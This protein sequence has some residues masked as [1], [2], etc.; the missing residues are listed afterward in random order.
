MTAAAMILN[1]REAQDGYICI[2][3]ESVRVDYTC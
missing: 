3:I 2:E 1:E